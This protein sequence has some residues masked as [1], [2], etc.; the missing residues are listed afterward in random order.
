MYWPSKVWK[1][2]FDNVALLEQV[3]L[4]V[5]DDITALFEGLEEA[6]SV[7]DRPLMQLNLNLPD[8]WEGIFLSFNLSFECLASLWFNCCTMMLRVRGH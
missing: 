7:V 6:T 8:K 4:L 3:G 1:S 2:V 5:C